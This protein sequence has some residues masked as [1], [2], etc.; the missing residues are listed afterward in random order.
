M[1]RVVRAVITV[2]LSLLVILGAVGLSV[3]FTVNALADPDVFYKAAESVGWKEGVRAKA[4]SGFVSLSDVTDIPVEVTDA[5]LREDVTD[6]ICMRFWT[7]EPADFPTDELTA[8]LA[9]RIRVCAEQMREKGEITVS[10]EDWQL[11]E[12]GFGETA[13]FYVSAVRRAVHLNGMTSL[14]K[15]ALDHWEK[16]FF[17]VTAVCLILTAVGWTVLL[18]IHRKR[19]M[20]VVYAALTGTGLTLL[21]PAIWLRASDFAAR[22]RITPDYFRDFLAKLYD[23]ATARLLITGAVIAALGLVCGIV[24]LILNGRKAKTP[25]APAEEGNKA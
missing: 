6:E 9:E 16:L 8:A 23:M 13:G 1:K 2:L 4:A 25:V 7:S 10:D 22:L 5:C 12:E 17:P 19:M 14:K 24:A 20:P 11:L 3:A 21:A 15:S 18:L